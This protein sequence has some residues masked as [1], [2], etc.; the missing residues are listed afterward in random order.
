MLCFSLAIIRNERINPFAQGKVGEKRLLKL[1]KP[2]S[3]H[4]VPG[5]IEPSFFKFLSSLF[6]ND[7][8]RENAIVNW[9]IKMGEVQQGKSPSSLI[10]GAISLSSLNWV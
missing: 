7:W 6:F 9:L 8:L 3:G 4:S 2:F 10:F 5:D 1:V